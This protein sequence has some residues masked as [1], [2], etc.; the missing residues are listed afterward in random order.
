MKEKI[1]NIFV[2][3]LE[4]SNSAFSIIRCYRFNILFSVLKPASSPYNIA[5][6]VKKANEALFMDNQNLGEREMKVKFKEE[7]VDYEPSLTED[8]VNSIE[9]DEVSNEVNDCPKF[10]NSAFSDESVQSVINLNVDNEILEE[11]DEDTDEERQPESSYSDDGNSESSVKEI[12]PPDRK[13]KRKIKFF[14]KRNY[15]SH[16][17]EVDCKSH[18]IESFDLGLR[19]KKLNIHEKVIVKPILKLQERKCCED[20]NNVK[21]QNLPV[22]A[23]FRSEYGLSKQQL[24]RRKRIREIVRMKQQKR[25]ELLQEFKDRKRQQNEEVFCQWLQDVNKRKNI[26]TRMQK[27]ETLSPKIINLPPG[28]KPEQQEKKRPQTAPLP[29]KSQ[30]FIRQKRRPQ[31][32][33]AYVYIQVPNNILKQGL[34]I[35]NVYVSLASNKNKHNVD[36]VARY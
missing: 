27:K 9:S 26:N 5:D 13:I 1:V 33:P 22:Y 31:T 35:G 18:C 36:I 12:R 15:S 14:R 32:S 25:Q 28:N 16:N 24:E 3:C 17:Y 29:P 23:G 2:S 34:S 4:F 30:F 20:N 10:Y 21:N 11:V 6:K 19:I 7:L 8:D